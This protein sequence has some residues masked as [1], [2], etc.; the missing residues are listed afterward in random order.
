MKNRTMVA[1]FVLGALAVGVSDSAS[2]QSAIGG[3]AKTKMNTVGGAAKPA[4]ALGGA[5][6]PKPTPVVATPVVVKPNIVGGVTKQSSVIGTPTPLS[7]ASAMTPS[8]TGATAKQNPPVTPP[9]KSKPVV[10]TTST[11]LKCA[12]GACVAKGT[13]L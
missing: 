7:N 12:A 3:P 13:K 4:P 10:V 9:K 5:K 8:S 6:T 1:A 11:N 2:A